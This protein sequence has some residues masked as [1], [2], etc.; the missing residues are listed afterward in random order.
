MSLN[1]QDMLRLLPAVLRIR[2]LAQAE[3]SPGWLDAADR[4]NYLE[5][6]GVLDSGG[7]LTPAQ[8][9]IY[10]AV[11]ERGLAGPL[12]SLIGLLAEQ[13]AALQENVE[14]LYD[15]QFIETCADWVVPY[16]GDLIGYR[17]LHGVTP[18]IASPRAEVAHTIG[19]RR[20]KGTVVCLEQLAR[21]VTGWSAT[22]VEFFQRIVVSQSMNHIRPQCLASP[23]MRNGNALERLNTAFDPVMHTIDVRRIASESG[24]YNIPNIG[25]FLW[26][27]SSWPLTG[28]P[29]ISVD[30][31]RWR[32]H[33]LGID[34]PLY[35]HALPI[36]AF[37]GMSKPINVPEPISR[38]V[39]D[40]GKN[41]YYGAGLSL[42]LYE[43]TGGTV[44]PVPA[45]DVCI[46]NLSDHAGTWAHL[47]TV[48]GKYAVDPVLGRIGARVDLPAG[49]SLAVDFQ[50]GFS[51]PMGGGEY[52][53]EAETADAS[54]PANLILVPDHHAHIQDAIAA[55]GAKGGVVEIRDS[56]RYEEALAIAAPANSQ[57]VLRAADGY[58]PT[59]VLT[60]P[61][62]IGGGEQSA[63]RLNGL[64]IAGDTLTVGSGGSNALGVLEIAHCTLVPGIALHPDGS[65]VHRQTPGIDIDTPGVA[66]TIR[67]SIV[68]GIR[69]HA[70][71][72]ANAADSIIDATDQTE[73]AYAD[74]DNESAGGALSLVNC[75]VVGKIHARTLPLVS[76]SILMARLASPDDWTAP[77]VADRLQEGCIRFTYLSPGARVPR[78]YHCL[79]ESADTVDLGTP[80][81]VTLRYGSPA[82]AKLDR[83]SGDAVRG[84]ADN[85]CE[86]GVFNAV[87]GV[88]REGNLRLRLS[89]Y[90]RVG[91]EAGIFYES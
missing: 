70:L 64:L 41:D 88:Q 59:I 91:L 57:I 68:G 16:I 19:Y 10:G 31:R 15:D 78:R 84:G 79:P 22:A 81:F 90:L 73:V 18:A 80:H 20:R 37:S 67:Q 65:P 7:V 60:A 8:Q 13:I 77:I 32:F 55:L 29:A 5:L 40:A 39:L 28:S 75:T 3:F 23:D 27:I 38:R 46:C 54:A 34:Q 85:D 21:D 83:S 35:S 66:L 24:R 58:R 50:Y 72:S 1:P 56:G 12:A 49:T 44:T 62:V 47:P 33:P 9:Q 26:S 63:V 17:M 76:N 4:K 6:Q 43:L 53:R 48:N 36:V 45:T 71:S 74:H 89:E 14:Q 42:L 25:M 30:S 86:P 69:V 11:R 2:D 61:L 51:A 87:A 52:D 82:Y